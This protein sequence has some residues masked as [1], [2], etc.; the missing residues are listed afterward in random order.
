MRFE[1]GLGLA[2][3]VS[4]FPFQGPVND[5]SP[6]RVRDGDT[7]GIAIANENR[8]WRIDNGT[9][10]VVGSGQA[11]SA[12]TYL[13]VQ[14]ESIHL[15]FWLKWNQKWSKSLVVAKLVILRFGARVIL[16]H[17]ISDSCP[18]AA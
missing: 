10:S 5:V 17:Y 15:H 13:K 2:H 8:L 1:P 11:T 12:L 9:S 3:L 14:L 7:K 6:V 4:D 16:I 18:G